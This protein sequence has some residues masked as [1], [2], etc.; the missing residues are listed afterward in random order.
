MLAWCAAV[1]IQN[2]WRVQC[3]NSVSYVLLTCSPC[4]VI[5]N[6]ING[7]VCEGITYL[8]CIVVSY[9]LHFKKKNHITIAL[10]AEEQSQRDQILF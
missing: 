6:K 8:T 3:S 1:S 5:E 7:H 2:M 4:D 10:N 9:F